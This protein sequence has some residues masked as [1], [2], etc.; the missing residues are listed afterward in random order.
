[1]T[2]AGYRGWTT[3]GA[4]PEVRIVEREELTPRDL[5]DLLTWLAAAYDEGPWLPSHWDDLGPGPH[6][7]IDDEHGLAAHACI[8]WVPVRAGDHQ[9]TSGY[10]EDVA[11]RADVRGQGLGT[12]LVR[13]ARP[14]IEARSQ[15]GLLATG[16][17]DLYEREGWVRWQGPLSVVEPDG[18]VTPTPDEEGYVMALFLPRTPAGVT[19]GLPLTRPRRDPEESW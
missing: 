10:L 12:A 9:L 13:A 16:S 7:M 5:D 6:L 15:L 8:D 1:M 18:A 19:V 4:M 17:F 2:A 3:L 14:L 11:T